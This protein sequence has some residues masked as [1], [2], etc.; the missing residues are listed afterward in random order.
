MKIG[1]LCN[2]Y[3]NYEPKEGEP[4]DKYYDMDSV[5]TIQNIANSFKDHDVDVIEADENAYHRLINSKYDLIF[6]FAEGI[7]GRHRELYF[8]A[9]L[10]MLKIPYTGSSPLTM[11]LCFDKEMT[12]KMLLF[13]DIPTPKFIS[14]KEGEKPDYSKLSFP[15]IV[16]PMNEG[17]SIGIGDDS[18]IEREEDAQIRVQEI[19][20]KY[21]Q[22]ALVEEFMSGR[23]FT[24]PVIGNNNLEIMPIVEIKHKKNKGNN[25]VWDKSEK[26]QNYFECPTLPKILEKKI[27]DYSIK[28]FKTLDC[29]DWARI[30]FRCDSNGEPHVIEVNGIAGLS[31][32]SAFPFSAQ[33]AGMSFDQLLGK[34]LDNAIERYKLK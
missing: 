6:N 19:I 10:E 27:R 30:D 11:G 12:K 5:A 25:W 4:K 9:M 31:D 1:V 34:I 22:P 28:T 3:N 20:A 8:P 7:Q 29:R 2:C 14:V 32:H 21:R 16:K 24:V 17:S 13:H 15:V 23:E 26:S 18:I 33:K